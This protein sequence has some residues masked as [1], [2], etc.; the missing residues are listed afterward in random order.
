MKFALETFSDCYNDLIDIVA[1]YN[2]ELEHF[3]AEHFKL[4]V[5]KYRMIETAELHR[6]YTARIDG[7]L[8]GFT[9]FFVFASLHCKDLIQADEDSIFLLPGYRKGWTGIKFI[10]FV[11]ASLKAEGVDVI[12]HVSKIKHPALGRILEYLGYEP[13]ETIY[14]K[15]L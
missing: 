2:K 13:I 10:K 5:L 7:K 1:Q 11:E 6:L 3:P 12:H 15:R 8:I 9:S 14:R 4:D